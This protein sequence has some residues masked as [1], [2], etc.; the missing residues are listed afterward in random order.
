MQW[1]TGQQANR[2]IDMQAF[3][4]GKKLRGKDIQVKDSRNTNA[5]ASATNKQRSEV[6][7][8]TNQLSNQEASKES[9]RQI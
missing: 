4:L 7:K 8:Q 6:A 1:R 2:D 9:C 3:R 5:E